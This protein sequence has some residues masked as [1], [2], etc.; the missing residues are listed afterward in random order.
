MPRTRRSPPSEARSRQWA[1]RDAV[2]HPASSQR[3]TPE[4]CR[5]P[6]RAIRRGQHR[7]CRHRRVT[8]AREPVAPL[9]TTL[10]P[11][12][13]KTSG[14]RS[15]ALRD[16]CFEH[17]RGWPRVT[18]QHFRASC[19]QQRCSVP[20]TAGLSRSVE[21]SLCCAFQV[22]YLLRRCLSR[23]TALRVRAPRCLEREQALIHR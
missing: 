14:Q 5:S 9:S 15:P 17:R 8:V 4:G 7:S 6:E 19:S 23:R 10:R 21:L 11:R 13:R 16:R 20:V 2:S 22:S 12:R 18:V 1:F 3:S